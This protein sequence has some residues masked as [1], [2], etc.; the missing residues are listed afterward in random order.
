LEVSYVVLVGARDLEQGQVTVK[1]MESGQQELV[2]LEDVV[3]FLV[4]RI[5]G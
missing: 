3:D 1:D 2:A 5:R 4:E